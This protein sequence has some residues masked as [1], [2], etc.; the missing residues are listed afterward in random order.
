MLQIS[1]YEGVTPMM[2]GRINNANYR[3]M[4]EAIK[5]AMEEQK[6]KPASKV[7][8]EESPKKNKK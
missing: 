7:D 2:T 6:V 1:E 3:L 4:L 5:R 8:N